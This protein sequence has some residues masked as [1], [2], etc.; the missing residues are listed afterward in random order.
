MPTSQFADSHVSD[1]SYLLAEPDGGSHIRRCYAFTQLRAAKGWGVA[2]NSAAARHG[3]HSVCLSVR[4]V[5]NF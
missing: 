1:E 4:S 5:G 3:R 2:P